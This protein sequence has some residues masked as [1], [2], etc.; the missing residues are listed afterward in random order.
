GDGKSNKDESDVPEG[1]VTD[2]DGDGLGD[3]GV[4]DKNNN[5]VA[6]LVEKPD[7]E[8]PDT[9]VPGGSSDIDWQRCAPAA[10]GIG[11]PL[12]LLLPIG[13]ASQMHIPGL[14][15]MVEQVSARINGINRQL[16]QKNIELQKQLGIYNE[17]L[18]KQLGQ[19]D[20]M[21]KKASP[22]AGRIGGAIALAAAGALALGLLVNAC[23]PGAGSSGSSSS[24]K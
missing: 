20:L 23:A 14:S 2:K 16:A 10:A 13:L 4:T 15:P 22:E 17:P 11:L 6:D 7:A 9:K 8:T 1:K 18:A 19:I 24:S 3:T 21:L 12:L 5:G